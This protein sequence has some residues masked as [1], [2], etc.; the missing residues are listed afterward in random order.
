MLAK[1]WSFISNCL[2]FINNCLSF[3]NNCRK[4]WSFI[5]IHQKVLTLIIAV[6]ASLLTTSIALAPEI[7]KMDALLQRPDRTPDLSAQ[8]T[9]MD[10]LLQRAEQTLDLN[11]QITKMDALLQRADRTLHRVEAKQ[12]D[13][14]G[15]RHLAKRA[16]ARA[17]FHSAATKTKLSPRERDLFEWAAISASRAMRSK[18]GSRELVEAVTA[19][20]DALE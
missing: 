13:R 3:M 6:A 10:E 15:R 14:N 11:P 19:F 9:K 5:N 17:P 8:L 2:S 20:R 4:L 12:Q 1:L 16:N 7:K 18:T